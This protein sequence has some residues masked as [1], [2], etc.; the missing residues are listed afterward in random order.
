MPDGEEGHVKDAAELV[1]AVA[2]LVWP[3]IVVIVVF[4]L[5][6]TIKKIA[7]SRGFTVKVGE[8]ELTVQEISEKFVAITADIQGELASVRTAGT[9]VG[10]QEN[11]SPALLRNVLWVDDQPSNN[12]YEI[13][14]LEVLGVAV[15]QVTSTLDALTALHGETRLFDAVISDMGRIENGANNANAGLDLVQALRKHG[16]NVPTLIYTTP[17]GMDRRA[18][19]LVAGATGV[20]AT[21]TTLFQLL[22]TVGRFPGKPEHP[23]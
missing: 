22:R 1:S 2:S 10:V 21:P 5:L 15:V 4:R 14:Q 8:T 9:P 20:A 13:A 17:G 19:L 16:N 18:E 12:A 3:L 7:E 11:M 23:A 6:P